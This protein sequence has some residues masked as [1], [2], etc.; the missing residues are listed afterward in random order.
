[1]NVEEYEETAKELGIQRIPILI[2]FKDGEEFQRL[3]G[4]QY[5]DVLEK[6]IEPALKKKT[7]HKGGKNE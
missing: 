3:V 7:L 5:A 6:A 1:M 2:I 4:L